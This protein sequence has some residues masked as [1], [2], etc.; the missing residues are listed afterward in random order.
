MGSVCT[1][2]KIRDYFTADLLPE[3]GVVCPVDEVLF[4]VNK[5]V[6]AMSVEEAEMM[7]AVR[8]LG[9][10]VLE[11]QLAKGHVGGR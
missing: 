8:V 2:T 3:N 6:N 5:T 9:E 1:T 7:D 10:A 11:G 4:G